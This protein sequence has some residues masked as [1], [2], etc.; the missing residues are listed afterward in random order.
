MNMGNDKKSTVMRVPEEMEKRIEQFKET[1]EKK[2]IHLNT[3]DAMRSFAENAI[4]PDENLT[5]FMKR[6]KII[7]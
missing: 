5:D 2:G 7:K 6:I 4:H 1:M 3:T